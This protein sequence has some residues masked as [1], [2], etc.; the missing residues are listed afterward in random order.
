MQATKPKP[1]VFVL[2]PFSDEFHDLYHAGIKPACK[3]ADA[4]CERVDEQLFEGTILERIYN[5]IAKADV[6][7]A[8]LTGK[9]PNVFYETGY[10]HALGKKVVLL[11]KSAADIP[12][13]MQHY[14]H[15]IH[16]GRIAYLKEKLEQRIRWF[17]QQSD[18]EARADELPIQIY[19]STQLV[20]EG[21]H[22]T[23]PVLD[24]DKLSLKMNLY[25]PTTRV[26]TLD[27]AVLSLITPGFVNRKYHSHG[28]VELPDGRL[29]H[30]LDVP[31]PIM[32]QGWSAVTAGYVFN[33][34]FVIP[35]GGAPFVVRTFRP[36]GY[37][38]LTFRVD[39]EAVD[40][41]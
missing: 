2:M 24:G 34:N 23:L 5:Q 37:T 17:L 12:F 40:S 19:V 29:M 31:T 33:E 38:D 14:P 28:S 26:L 8:E 36:S 25:N 18:E 4:Y 15:I 32:P 30:H 13:D 11:T 20:T 39:F 3:D 41:L 35:L 22:L 6:V 10:A 27:D 7:V 9:N 1:F 21:C 16:E